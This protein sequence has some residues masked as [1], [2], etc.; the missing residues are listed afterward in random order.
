MQLSS[1]EGWNQS[2]GGG[3]GGGE[4]WG[5][6]LTQP[7]ILDR[8]HFL[9][10]SFRGLNGNGLTE[11]PAGIF[12][13]LALLTRLYVLWLVAESSFVSSLLEPDIF[14]FF[15]RLCSARC[16]SI[17]SLLYGWPWPISLNSTMQFSSAESWNQNSSGGGGHWGMRLCQPWILDRLDF[18]ILSEISLITT[19]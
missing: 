4:Q 5:I 19:W 15:A 1:A 16:S 9:L 2:S 8:F 7:W 11:L 17:E 14:F 10:L 3:G 12:D 18:L 13:S 6:R